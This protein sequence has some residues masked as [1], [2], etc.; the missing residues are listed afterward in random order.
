MS[1]EL[2]TLDCLVH[3][4][5]YLEAPDLLRAARVNQAWNEAAG[6]TSLW[7]RLCLDRWTFCNI[8]NLTPGKI[9]GMAYLSDNE[10]VFGGGKLRSVVCTASTDGTIRAW[11]V[12]EGTQ[13]WS[14]PSQEVPFIKVITVPEYKLAISTDARGTIKVWHGESG[15]ELAAFSTS[16]SSSTLVT[17]SVNN[18][19][20]LTAATAGGVIYTL[21]VPNLNQVSCI[22]AFQNSSIDLLLC[23]PDEQWLVAGSTENADTSSKIFYTDCL[24]NPADESPASGSLPVNNCDVGCWLPKAPA[25]IAVMHQDHM[26]VQRNITVFDLAVKKSKYK[27]EVL[28]QQVASFTLPGRTWTTPILMKGHG[29][30]TILLGCGSN[31]ELY[32]IFGT[33][34]EAF[35]HHNNTITS[36]WVDAFR[37]ITSSLDLSLRVYTWKKVN[38]IS[39]LTSRYYLLGGTHRWSRGFMDVA[40]DNISIVGVV[41][42][43]D[44]TSILRAYSFNL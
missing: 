25:R 15:E 39:S 9:V 11:Q 44:G 30:E 18:K 34:L 3:V 35:Q 24:I 7:R 31:L 14:S 36:I 38:K 23:S 22:T 32:S 12:Q 33:Q 21:E 40:C 29:T 16:S 8:S 17:Y 43:S 6:T 26:S 28:A 20:F 10:H 4:F 5:S 19:P 1:C 13:I 27:M 41:A 2:L 42:E 37:V